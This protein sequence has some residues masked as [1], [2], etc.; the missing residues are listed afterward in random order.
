MTTATS[1][2]RVSSFRK[3]A[4]SSARRTIMFVT[5]SRAD[6][7]LLAPIISACRAKSQLRVRVVAAGEHLLMPANTWK[8][9]AHDQPIDLKVPMQ[10]RADRGRAD[11]AHAL[12]R[13]VTGFARAFDQLKPDWLVVLGDRIEALAAAAAAAV[14]GV[15]ICHIHGGDRAE[16]IADESIRHAVSKLSQLHCVA[17][18]GS[19]DRLLRMGESPATVHITGSPALDALKACKPLTDQEARDLLGAAYKARAVILLHP[20]GRAARELNSMAIGAVMLAW[21]LRTVPLVLAPNSDPGREHITGAYD[22]IEGSSPLAPSLLVRR[23]HLPR[24][25]FVG[26]LKRLARQRPAGL[27]IGNSSA[28]LIE[29]AALGLTCVN[30]GPRQN[31]RERADNVIDMPKPTGDALAAVSDL[32]RAANFAGPAPSTQ[33]GDGRAAARI[34]RL[35]ATFRPRLR[36]LNTY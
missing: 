27:L 13:G 25:A 24:P 10:R 2:P 8:L 26:L 1:K 35:L 4:Q 36:K 9:V 30:I 29:A 16:G 21:S 23:D 7:G 3:G 11:H 22:R 15:P 34:A 17:T 31:G 32:L 5:G 33:F 19:R 20:D 18:S 28:G 6:Y 12:A 14:A